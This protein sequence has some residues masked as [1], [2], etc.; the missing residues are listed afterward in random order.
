VLRRDGVLEVHRLLGRVLRLPVD[1]V[2]AEMGS[3]TEVRS[4][5]RWAVGIDEFEGAPELHR[6][7]RARKALEPRAVR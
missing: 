4:R 5:R 1:E 7:L 2:V 3:I 6:A